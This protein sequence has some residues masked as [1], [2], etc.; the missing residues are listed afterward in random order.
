[1]YTASGD[2]SIELMLDGKL[3]KGELVTPSTRN[4]KEAIAWRQWQRI[5]WVAMLRRG[6]NFISKIMQ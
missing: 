3:F 2:G 5:R 1:M 4:D 6:R